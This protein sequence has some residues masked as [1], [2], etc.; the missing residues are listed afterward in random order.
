MG[1][2]L[3]ATPLLSALKHQYPDATLT[4]VTM[5][6]NQEFVNRLSNVDEVLVLDDRSLIAMAITTLQTIVT[7]IR[8]RADLY[9]DLEVYSAFA[10]LLA[11]CAMT[12]NR[13][14]FYRHS[15]AFKN[16]IYTHLVYFSSVGEDRPD[17]G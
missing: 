1:S 16:G 4:F 5:R 7:L 14:G 3:Q 10:S 12:R 11:L 8:L 13:L 17:S 6:G 15:T 9:F 2:I